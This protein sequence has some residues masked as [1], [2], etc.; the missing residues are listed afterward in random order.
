MG[1]EWPSSQETIFSQQTSS[2]D[3]VWDDDKLIQ[4]D[5]IFVNHSASAQP[6]ESAPDFKMCK[7]TI[8]AQVLRHPADVMG[9][10]RNFAHITGFTTHVVLDPIKIKEPDH[11]TDI[12][13]AIIQG[14]D[15]GYFHTWSNALPHICVLGAVYSVHDS[16]F[17][18]QVAFMRA[19]LQHA[20]CF[21]YRDGIFEAPL[22][23]A[24]PS[25]DPN[26]VST[27]ETPLA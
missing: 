19:L 17:H 22:G 5:N 20:V 10:D 15:I 24:V 14:L 13:V 27:F 26:S 18:A 21:I 6:S 8:N 25:L 7:C 16:A 9:L 11:P 23:G 3:T 1:N 12:S 2:T 4:E